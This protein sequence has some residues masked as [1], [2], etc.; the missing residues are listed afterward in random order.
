[1]LGPL[2]RAVTGSHTDSGELGQ[3]FGFSLGWFT[4]SSQTQGGNPQSL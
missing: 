4:H 2:N 1:M 3:I